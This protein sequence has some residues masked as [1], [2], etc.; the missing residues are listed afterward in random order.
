MRWAQN[1]KEAMEDFFFGKQAKCLAIIFQK[2]VTTKGLNLKNPLAQREPH[3][4][5][6]IIGK[7]H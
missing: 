1:R 5:K 4:N 2:T 3:L 6:M 7:E